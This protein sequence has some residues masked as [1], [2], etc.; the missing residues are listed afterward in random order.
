MTRS[1]AALDA[2]LSPEWQFRYYSFDAAW[3]PG[4]MLASMRDGEGDRWVGLICPAGIVII[5]LSHESSAFRPGDPH[6]WIFR[7]LP[8]AFRDNAQ[9][10]PAFDALNASFCLWCMG[11]QW[12][13]GTPPRGIDDGSADLMSILNGDPLQYQAFASEYFEVSIDLEDIAAVY[14]HAPMTASIARRINP[15][16][17]VDSLMKEL[18]SMGYPTR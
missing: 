10:E 13:C 7:D 1:L 3:A 16:V 11:G 2:V 14:R 17:D 15:E 4:E 5:G 18:R 12:A 6:E 8:E 9:R